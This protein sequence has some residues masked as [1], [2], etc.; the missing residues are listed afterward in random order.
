MT[1]A[2]WW[3]VF[4]ANRTDRDKL[5]KRLGKKRYNELVEFAKA[6]PARKI[7]KH[8]RRIAEGAEPRN[9]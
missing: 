7:D 5:D 1:P 3:L 4:D 6:D 9:T 8:L 2:E